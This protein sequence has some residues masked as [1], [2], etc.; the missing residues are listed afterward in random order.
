MKSLV[1]GKNIK[2]RINNGN[3]GLVSEYETLR[4]IRHVRVEAALQ[5][6]FIP[7]PIADEFTIKFK[8]IRVHSDTRVLAQMYN[9]ENFTISIEAPELTTIFSGCRWLNIKETCRA[10]GLLI[11]EAEIMASSRHT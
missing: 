9:A 1:S 8:R 5:S 11:D 7:V 6:E 10:D 2:L 4:R 3:L